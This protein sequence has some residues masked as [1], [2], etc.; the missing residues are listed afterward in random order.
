MRVPVVLALFAAGLLATF[1][2]SFGVGRAVGPVDRPGPA[3]T[4]TTMDPSMDMG[5]QP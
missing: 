4:S 1:A 3:V 5:A 2:L